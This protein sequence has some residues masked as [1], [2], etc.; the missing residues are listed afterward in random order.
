MTI[1]DFGD[2][3]TCAAIRNVPTYHHFVAQG[4]LHR[5]LTEWQP[6]M[7]ATPLEYRDALYKTRTYYR[8]YLMTQKS[9]AYRE[10]LRWLAIA[11]EWA[12]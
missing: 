2:E 8:T 3:E 1:A 9:E 7:A 12:Q 5:L 11:Q 4:R 6:V 10:Y